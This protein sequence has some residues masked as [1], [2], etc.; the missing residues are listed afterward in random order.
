MREVGEVGGGRLSRASGHAALGQAAGDALRKDHGDVLL[1]QVR[2]L[3][4][5]IG[6]SC[7]LGEYWSSGATLATASPAEGPFLGGETIL[8]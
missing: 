1:R 4:H 6:S 3:G 2:A 7:G 8:G 5:L